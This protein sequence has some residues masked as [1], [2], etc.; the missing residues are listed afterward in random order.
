MLGSSVKASSPCEDRD[1]NAT[2]DQTK[3]SSYS[4]TLELNRHVGRWFSHHFMVSLTIKIWGYK[5]IIVDNWYMMVDD[6]NS[7]PWFLRG[8][9]W[10][11]GYGFKLQELINEV[12]S[13]GHITLQWKDRFWTLL[14]WAQANLWRCI[15]LTLLR[16]TTHVTP[17]ITRYSIYNR[18]VRWFLPR[19]RMPGLHIQVYEPPKPQRDRTV[20]P[21]CN[22]SYK[23]APPS[24]KLVHSL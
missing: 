21:V 18:V 16:V 15:P 20:V 5:S 22:W 7:Y 1:F 8:K 14:M 23:V 17:M 6:Q 11:T 4:E 3:C 13:K 24:C 9:S 12:W 10:W 2:E 19:T